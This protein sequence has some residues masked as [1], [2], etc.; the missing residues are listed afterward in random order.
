MDYTYKNIKGVE[1]TTQL[2]HPKG[3]TTS[4]NS[5][6]ISNVTD[7]D[8][9][10]I[11]L[12]IFK[13][14][15]LDTNKTPTLSE[16]YYIIKN[17]EIAQGTSVVFDSVD[18]GYDTTTHDLYLELSTRKAN[19]DIKLETEG[20]IIRKDWVITDEIITSGSK[21]NYKEVLSPTLKEVAAYMGV[22]FRRL[23]TEVVSFM[24]QGPTEI[25]IDTGK[26]VKC[27]KCIN[28]NSP[29][30][31]CIFGA[32]VNIWKWCWVTIDDLPVRVPCGL[33]LTIQL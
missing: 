27:K 2:I 25:E 29:G 5:L 18:M 28:H 30:G 12:F 17:L 14:S 11:N 10:K 24:V 31:V 23:E 6:L 4:V 1:G 19:V 15:E 26:K 22:D 33:T 7:L 8:S 32:C 21:V 9:F 16:S 13:N 20:D 3:I